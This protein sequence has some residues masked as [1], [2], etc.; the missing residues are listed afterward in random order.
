MA[1]KSYLTTAYFV[2][3]V[4]VIPSNSKVVCGLLL[5]YNHRVEQLNRRNLAAHKVEGVTL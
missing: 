4:S 1:Q 5:S 2:N 3:E